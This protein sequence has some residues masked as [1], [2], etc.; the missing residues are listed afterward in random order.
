MIISSETNLGVVN[1][2][3]ENDILA[4][5]ADVMVHLYSLTFN[6][7]MVVRQHISGEV[8]VFTPAASTV[9][10]RMG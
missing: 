9:H 4:V 10:I 5:I 7:F 8:A 1:E 6:F 3:A 2:C